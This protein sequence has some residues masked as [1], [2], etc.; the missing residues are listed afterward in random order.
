MPARASSAKDGDLWFSDLEPFSFHFEQQCLHGDSLI[1]ARAGGLVLRT[2][3][4]RLLSVESVRRLFCP[5]TS[6]K[7]GLSFIPEHHY[8]F[9]RRTIQPVF[10]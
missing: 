2:D 6:R 1:V 10:F 5:L 3:R 4:V 7:S 9:S 8:G